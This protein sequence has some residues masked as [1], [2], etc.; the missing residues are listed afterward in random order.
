MPSKN[1]PNTQDASQIFL[2]LPEIN[3]LCTRAARGAGLSWGM[4]E[5]CG[6]GAQWLAQNGFDWASGILAR[7]SGPRGDD[8]VPAP[9]AW[10]C[11]GPICALYAGVTLAEFAMLREGPRERALSIGRVYDPICL[12]P[13]VARTTQS[14]GAGLDVHLDDALWVRLDGDGMQVEDQHKSADHCAMVTLHPAPR[15]ARYCASRVLQQNGGAVARSIYARF[16]EIALNMTVPATARSEAGAGG[17]G[18]DT[19]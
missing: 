4:A 11:D 5:E 7:L 12:L 17:D 19:D 15:N 8:V 18:P 6:Y 2:S 13:F 16:E 1:S 10:Q 9:A 3:A 14:I